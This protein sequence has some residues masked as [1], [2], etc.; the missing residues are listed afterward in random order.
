[1]WSA[2]DLLRAGAGRG[3]PHRGARRHEFPLSLHEGNHEGIMAGR[4]SYI[5]QSPKTEID[6]S[7]FGA[8]F[9]RPRSTEERLQLARSQPARGS[10]GFGAS[11]WGVS[12]PVSTED[13]L[14]LALPQPL[15]PEDSS[16]GA[17]LRAG[18]VCSKASSARVISEIASDAGMAGVLSAKSITLGPRSTD[19]RRQLARDQP[20]VGELGAA[21]GE[22]S[23]ASPKSTEDRLQLA[24]SQF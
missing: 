3:R 14:Q 11:G 9:C 19:E 24:L 21:C 16:G 5:A 23:F 13:R 17:V 2:Y 15:M 1:M 10:A 22:M 18:R 20:N 7:R 6:Q 8:S 12:L 4:H